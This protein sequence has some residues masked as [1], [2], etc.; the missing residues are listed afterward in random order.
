MNNEMAKK[1]L[2]EIQ[3]I[4]D[5]VDLKFWFLHGT[6][7]GAWRDKNFI[8][9]DKDIDL[10]IKFEDF[11]PKAEI[12]EK[13]FLSN[14]F[15]IS[16]AYL[17]YNYKNFEKSFKKKNGLNTFPFQLLIEKYGERASIFA[18]DLI[19]EKRFLLLNYKEECARVFDATMF[20][21][22]KEIDFLGRKF[23]IPNETEKYLDY[24]YG[25]GY[26]KG[27]GKGWRTPYYNPEIT[28]RGS[29]VK[30]FWQVYGKKIIANECKK[31][32]KKLI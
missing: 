12:L 11:I 4:L 19:D 21:N 29:I 3:D 15:R 13:E 32:G 1:L 25:K 10:G 16:V 24:E 9:N 6:C 20:E 18:Y 2:F 17:F 26:G 5:K 8:K 7:L 14:K 28:A 30:D 31:K 23:L 27:F 22:L